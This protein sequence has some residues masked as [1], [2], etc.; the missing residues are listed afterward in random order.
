MVDISLG[1]DG[2]LGAQLAGAGLGGC[3]MLLV[4]EQAVPR[5]STM[6]EQHYYRQEGKPVS[7]LRCRPIGGSSV[8]FA[9]TTE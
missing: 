4:H 1:V 7:I 8:L 9:T 6:L 5:V 2:V 3:M